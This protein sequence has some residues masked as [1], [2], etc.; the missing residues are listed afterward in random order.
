MSTVFPAFIEEKSLQWHSEKM[1]SAVYFLGA[2]IFLIGL[3][4]LSSWHLGVVQ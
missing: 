4:F 2:S 3:I 1:K